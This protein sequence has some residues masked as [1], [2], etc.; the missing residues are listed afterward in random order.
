MLLD[1]GG[2]TFT[3]NLHATVAYVL[4]QPQL[5]TS[6]ML[7]PGLTYETGVVFDVA[8]SASG[9]TLTTSRRAFAVKL[10]R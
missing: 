6:M 4:N 1:A 9:F 3:W 8:P 2:R 7:Q 10:D 5:S